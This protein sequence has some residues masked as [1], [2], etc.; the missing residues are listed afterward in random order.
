M[1]RRI[2]S[3]E[4][5][6]YVGGLGCDLRI[7]IGIGDSRLPLPFRRLANYWSVVP[8]TWKEQF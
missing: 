3:A 2:G 6:R 4:L 5:R 8:L 7:S 1:R